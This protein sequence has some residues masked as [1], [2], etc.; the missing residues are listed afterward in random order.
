VVVD[1][2]RVGVFS[3]VVRSKGFVTLDLEGSARVC[4]W[5]HAGK[6]LQVQGV[7]DPRVIIIITIIIITMFSIIITIN[8]NITIVIIITIIIVTINYT[9]TITI[10]TTITITIIR[11]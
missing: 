9:I 10:N 8:I 2:E 7:G 3:G 4:Y 1:P 5:S 11:C 6:R